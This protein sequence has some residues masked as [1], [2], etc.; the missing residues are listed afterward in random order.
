VAPTRPDYAYRVPWT[1]VLALIALFAILPAAAG[2]LIFD[3]ILKWDIPYGV[4]L[5]LLIAG[6]DLYWF[7]V[8][9]AYAADL[10]SGT[11]RWRTPLRSGTFALGQLRAVRP[12]WIFSNVQVLQRREARPVL[13]WAVRGFSRF[14]D[15]VVVQRP[16]LP[17]RFQLQGRL[18]ERMPVRSSFRP[19]LEGESC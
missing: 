16:D 7:L 6:W 9:F 5:W 19:R 10:D 2:E 18:A 8:R 4:I 12:S 1:Q 15:S 14:M 17:V 13:L 11:L 3:V